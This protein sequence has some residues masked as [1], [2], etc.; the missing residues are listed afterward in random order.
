LLGDFV[1]IEHEVR[2]RRVG[3]QAAST[4]RLYV[5]AETVIGYRSTRRQKKPIGLCDSTGA[6]L[7]PKID[8]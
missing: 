1:V 7:F 3:Q 4:V 2:Q 6:T 8:I 5:Y